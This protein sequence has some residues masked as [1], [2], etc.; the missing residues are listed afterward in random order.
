MA[1]SFEIRDRREAKKRKASE[2]AA[3]GPAES[4]G[5]ARDGTHVGQ[6]D[7]ENTTLL[8]NAR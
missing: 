2:S 6:H 5:A 7:N 8:E 4:S 1:I 3:N